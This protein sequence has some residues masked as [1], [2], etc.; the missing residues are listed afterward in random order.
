[1]RSAYRSL[2]IWLG[3]RRPVV[4]LAAR[5]QPGLDRMLLRISR[6]HVSTG[7][8]LPALLLTGT[9]RRSGEPHT[10]PLFYVPAESGWA[11]VDT[12]YGRPGR[13]AWSLNLTADPSCTVRIEGE[14]HP[15]VAR[16]AEGEERERLWASLIE[17][18]PLYGDYAAK[19]GR[20][21]SVWVLEGA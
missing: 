19:G 3:R 9:G 20:D 12:S 15:C 8:P 2:L 14:E 5:V 13:P 11:V 18:W 1:M 21:P 16:I 10:V 4:A 6:G 7:G 17:M